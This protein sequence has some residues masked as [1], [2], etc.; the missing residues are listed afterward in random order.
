V[1]AIRKS[2]VRAT[3]LWLASEEYALPNFLGFVL[4]GWRIQILHPRAGASIKAIS[5]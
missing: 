1:P 4:H 2:H 3:N 5:P